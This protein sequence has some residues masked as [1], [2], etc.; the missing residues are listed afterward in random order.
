MRQLRMDMIEVS[1]KLHSVVDAES[2][3]VSF[4]SADL[5]GGT[6]ATMRI[7]VQMFVKKFKTAR[8]LYVQLADMLKA[9]AMQRGDVEA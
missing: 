2:A 9:Y 4:S 6:N 7:S 5:E 3:T 1:E 8:E